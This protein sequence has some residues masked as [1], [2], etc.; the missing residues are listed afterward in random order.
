MDVNKAIDM[1]IRTNF[2]DVNKKIP[3]FIDNEIEIC[4]KDIQNFVEKVFPVK[5]VPICDHSFE[6]EGLVKICS[7]CDMR[8]NI[9]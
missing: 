2:E 7:K 9:G 3:G 5:S 4:I 6:G 8:F 1:I